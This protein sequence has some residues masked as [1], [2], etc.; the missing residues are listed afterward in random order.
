V[1]DVLKNLRK[2]IFTPFVW[3]LKGIMIIFNFVSGV[4]EMT[5]ESIVTKAF[6]SVCGFVILFILIPISLRVDNVTPSDIILAFA[7]LMLG[8]AV[9]YHVPHF[10][11]RKFTGKIVT[12]EK[13]A[14]NLQSG[15]LLVIALATVYLDYQFMNS[16]ANAVTILALILVLQNKK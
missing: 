5:S 16:V 11:Y 9:L 10:F 4:I 15:L 2:I 3:L 8:V 14:L 1:K 6:L 12:A 13:R 7:A